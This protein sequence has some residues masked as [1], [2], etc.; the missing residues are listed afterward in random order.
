MK[1]GQEI[2]K[3]RL[4]KGMTQEELA[5]RT[6][7][8]VRTIQRIENGDVDPRAYTLQTIASALEVEFEKLNSIREE[9]IDPVIAQQR[10]FWLPLLHLSGLFV[11]LFPPLII[12]LAK[13]DQIEDIKVHGVEVINFQL[14]M[15][16]ILVPCGIFAFLLI[17]IPIMIIIGIYSTV[18]IILNTIRVANHQPYKYPTFFKILK[19]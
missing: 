6:N 12:W 3:L 10:E 13:K 7:L 4:D 5:E 9:E 1:I 11:L 18:I 8:S 17:T 19:N 2:K 14:S 16:I 15:W